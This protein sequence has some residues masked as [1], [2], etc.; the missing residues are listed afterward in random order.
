M[1]SCAYACAFTYAYVVNC[2]N[3]PL[4]CGQCMVQPT[5]GVKHEINTFEPHNVAAQYIFLYIFFCALF[6][7]MFD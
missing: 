6:I 4:G 7:P 3:Q 1:F 5:A 2:V